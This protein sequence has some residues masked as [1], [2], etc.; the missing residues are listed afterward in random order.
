[1]ILNINKPLGLTSYDVVAY[2]KRITG[3]QKVGHAGTL[4]PMATGVLLVAVGRPSTRRISEFMDQNKEYEADVILGAETDTLDREGPLLQTLPV[5]PLSRSAI[6]V[7]LATFIGNI[8]QIPPM[9]SA[10]HYKGKRAYEIAREGKTI[11]LPPRRVEIKKI[12][13]LAYPDFENG[14]PFPHLTLR[15]LCEKGVY[16]RSLARDIG[17]AWGTVAFLGSL[18]RTRIGSYT[19]AEGLALE[20]TAKFLVE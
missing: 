15:I 11:F 2:V 19:S 9:Y 6:D 16:I 12:D 17:E 1:M 14:N 5:P 10:V 18:E 7:L 4:D 20:G 13:V 3:E 8:D